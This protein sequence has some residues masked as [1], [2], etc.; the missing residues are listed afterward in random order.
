MKLRYTL[1]A[2]CAVLAVG[3][4][5]A[6]ADCAGQISDVDKEL[7]ANT[8]QASPQDAASSGGD[9]AETVAEALA[10]AKAAAADG[11]EEECMAALE[12]AKELAGKD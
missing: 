4:A 10:E 12:R 1:M 11:N 7:R 6:Q 3:T 2:G 5:A 8:A 9:G